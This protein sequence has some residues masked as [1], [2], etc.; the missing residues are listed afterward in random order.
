MRVRRVAVA[1]LTAACLTACSDDAPDPADHPTYVA[2]GDSYTAAP[3]VP[4]TE[5]T[6]GCSRSDRNYPTLVAESLGADLTDVS[7]SGATTQDL[8][9]GQQTGTVTQDPQFDALSEDTSLVTLGMGGNDGGLFGVVGVRCMLLGGIDPTGSP[10]EAQTSSEVEQ[11]LAATQDSL[12]E[13]VAAIR[14]RAPDATVLVVGYP[15]LVPETGTC[16]ILPLADGDYAYVRGL[17]ADLDAAL[18][19]AAR[20]G[21]ATYVDVLTASA[22]HDVCAGQDAWVNGVENAPD[23]AIGLHPFGEEQAAVAALVEEA[24]AGSEG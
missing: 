21:G 17:V 8:T 16:P 18:E 23:R 1:L 4:T 12:T 14:D 15:Q 24:L 2:M 5:S 10:C 13:A 9:Q 6:S 11:I 7:C 22:G 3:G 20:A 19:E